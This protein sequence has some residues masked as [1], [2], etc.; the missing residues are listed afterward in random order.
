MILRLNPADD[1]FKCVSDVIRR[2]Y[3]SLQSDSD[4]D[5]F[6]LIHDEVVLPSDLILRQMSNL[7]WELD[8]FFLLLLE[9]M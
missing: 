9:E 4:I 5:R 7:D 2:A 3:R 8:E 6:A 1:S